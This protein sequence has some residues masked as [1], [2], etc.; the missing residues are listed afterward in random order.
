MSDL[1][2][3]TK[4]RP[5]MKKTH[6]H[7]DAP[8]TIGDDPEKFM[9]W[10]N[11]DLGI[12]ASMEMWFDES[13]VKF[14]CKRIPFG[15][16]M[17]T[18]DEYLIECV[19][20]GAIPKLPFND[21]I[22]EFQDPDGV[23]HCFLLDS[24]D[25]FNESDDDTLKH[26]AY[27]NDVDI[28]SDS[29]FDV[30]IHE[31]KMYIEDIYDKDSEAPFV[32]AFGILALMEEKLTSTFQ[33]HTNRKHRKKGKGPIGSDYRVLTLNLAAVRRSASRTARKQHESPRLHWRRGHWRVL[34][35]MSEYEKRVWVRKALV[36]DPDKGYVSKD[37]SLIWKPG[38]F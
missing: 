5:M 15:F 25:D 20:N 14:D 35:R 11:F 24:T 28:T 29:M 22:M 26:I 18:G 8:D 12:K 10:M 1:N 32:L 27:I 3:Y 38:V 19:E 2:L 36:G 21:L 34:H 9:S 6:K 4:I 7:V 23:T 30:G 16:V 13:R 17:E 37:Y 33:V 31:N